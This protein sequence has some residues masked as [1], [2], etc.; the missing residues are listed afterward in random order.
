MDP[1]ALAE[2]AVQAQVQ[3]GAFLV[4][5]V[6]CSHTPRFA[7]TTVH[8]GGNYTPSAYCQVRYV[9]PLLKYGKIRWFRY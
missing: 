5:G 4:D 1:G 3:M 6:V 8:R 9:I 2:C 7:R